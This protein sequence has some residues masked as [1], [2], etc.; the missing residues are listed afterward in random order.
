VSSPRKRG[1]TRGET[2][3]IVEPRFRGDDTTR[4]TVFYAASR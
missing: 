1:S 3:E 4:M 2:V